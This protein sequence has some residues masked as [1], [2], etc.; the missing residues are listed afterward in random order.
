A[1][2]ATLS[3]LRR[4]LR[5]RRQESLDLLHRVV[6]LDVERALAERGGRAARVAGD[7]VVL[8]RRRVGI[9]ALTTALAAG[10]GRRNR[11]ALRRRNQVLADPALVAAEIEHRRRI[12]NPCVR[13][14]R[15]A[16]LHEPFVE[17][18]L[19]L[20]VDLVAEVDVDAL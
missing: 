7:A 20:L 2:P 15:V 10:A 1:L 11:I 12:G 19:R 18:V 16:V 17:V 9:G 3:L 6:D 13:A 4:R 5:L 8:A 14:S